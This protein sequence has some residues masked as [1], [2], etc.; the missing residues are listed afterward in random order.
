MRRDRV[1]EIILNIYREALH[2]AT[3]EETDNFFD[4]GGNSLTAAKICRLIRKEMNASIAITDVFKY[5]NVVMLSEKLRQGRVEKSQQELLSFQHDE[6]G[7]YDKFPLTKIQ[8]GYVIGRE[9]GENSSHFY[10]ELK[11]EKLDVERFEK[12]IN[13]CYLN[14]HKVSEIAEYLGVSDSSYFRKRVL[15]NLE[16][17]GYLMKSK[18]SRAAYYKTNPDM[19]SV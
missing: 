18:V 2:D 7:R 14:A 13:F 12:V 9:S 5:P 16:K 6:A 8:Q 3:L 10:L 17:H 11:R 4:K 19:V 1:D 15:G